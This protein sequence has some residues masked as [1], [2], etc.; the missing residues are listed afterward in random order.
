[1]SLLILLFN[2]VMG[3]GLISPLPA[4]QAQEMTEAL[5]WDKRRGS[6]GANVREWQILVSLSEWIQQRGRVSFIHLVQN[7]ILTLELNF[8]KAEW[9]LTEAVLS[10]EEREEKD[11]EFS[12]P[13]GEF[14]LK[15]SCFGKWAERS[16][17]LP[18]YLLTHM[19]TICGCKSGHWTEN[20]M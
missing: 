2:T 14:P 8:C 16:C 9:D 17:I 13:H 10:G 1:M 4:F 7:W 5:S 20:K 18:C 12:H 11:G 19:Y 3:D 15:Q 6:P